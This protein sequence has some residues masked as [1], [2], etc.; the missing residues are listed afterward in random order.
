MAFAGELGAEIDLTKLI[1]QCELPTPVALFSESNTRF[2]V[3]VI[4]E[5]AEA[6]EAHFQDLP[7]VELGE[8]TNNKQLTIK[9]PTAGTIVDANIDELKAVWKAP[10]A[11]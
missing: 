1:N 5:Q 8:V 11:Y 3:E 9:D 10:L 7:L 6:F 2:V 4:P